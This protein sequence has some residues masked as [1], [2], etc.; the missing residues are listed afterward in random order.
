MK[1]EGYK[2]EVFLLVNSAT[3]S[4]KPTVGRCRVTL[5]NPH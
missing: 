4:V 1:V 3:Q 2:V 5:S